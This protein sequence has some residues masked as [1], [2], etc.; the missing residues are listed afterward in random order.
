MRLLRAFDLLK[1]ERLSDFADH[2]RIEP[3]L[4]ALQ[5]KGFKKRTLRDAF[6]ATLKQYC[7]YL[8]EENKVEQDHLARWRRLIVPKTSKKRRA[9]MPDEMARA[10]AASDCLDDLL[11]RDQPMRPLWTALLVAA[12]RV[13]ALA[14][15]DVTDLDQ[16]QGRLLLKGNDIKQAGAG[17]LDDATL[18]EITAYAKGRTGTLFLSPEGAMLNRSNSLKAW[19]NSLSLGFVDMEWPED[20]ERDL[21]IEYLVHYAL[22]TG[23]VQVAMGGPLSGS[24]KPGKAKLAARK[25]LEDRIAGIAD[26]IREGW[27]VGMKG[28]DQHCL[29]KT[30]RTWALASGVPEIMIDRQL[31]HS[32]PAGEA[33]LKA[34]W[35]VVAREHYT[36]MKFLTMSAK[37]SADAVREMLDTAEADLRKLALDGGTALVQP[38]EPPPLRMIETG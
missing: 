5:K 27:E 3:S 1:L 22:K 30:H 32:S 2:T 15:L 26:T 7:R 24:H 35:S 16:K 37:K 20:E 25:E 9:I 18:E 34:V 6:Q 19:R 31:G 12:P 4:L 21:G 23:K 38:D 13:S 17:V 14:E 36:D 28:V 11:F 8:F 10:L 29:R 33:A